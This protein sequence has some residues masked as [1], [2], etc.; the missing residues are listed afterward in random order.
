MTALARRYGDQVRRG[1]SGT[2]P[3]SRSSCCRSTASGK[4]VL[5]A[6]LPQALPRPP[7]AIRS[8]RR[9]PA[10]QD[11]DRR[12]V[13]ARERE[14]RRTRSPSCAGWR[15]W[16]PVQEDAQVLAAAGRRLRAP[17][18]HHADRPALRAAD[19][20]DVTIGVLDRLVNALDRAG[21][22]R[23]AAA[24]PADLPDRVRDP[25]RAGPDLRRLARAPAR[26]L[27]DRRAHG[28]RQ[29]ARGAV[30]AVPDA[31]RPAARG[32]LPLPRLRERP[33]APTASASR[34]TAR[35]RT[36]SRSSATGRPTCCGG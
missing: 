23:R 32:G 5:A 25:V 6:A 8:V 27:R 28:V 24:R 29:P 2:S 13:A 34:P 16:T 22:R 12:D 10:R 14:H 15:A 19:K 36:R 9:Q 11:P 3:T 17:R 35:S 33:A 30:L 4:P 21:A 31:R 18:V 7:S 26:V 1:R 20:D